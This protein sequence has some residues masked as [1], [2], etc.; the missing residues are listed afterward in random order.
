MN[1][2]KKFKNEE[3][4]SILTDLKENFNVVVDKRSQTVMSII[5]RKNNLKPVP[6]RFYAVIRNEKTGGLTFNNN[7]LEE[8]RKYNLGQDKNTEYFYIH[9]DLE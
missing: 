8:L 6:K 2:T 3:V 5:L 1:Q 4:K 9:F 7:V